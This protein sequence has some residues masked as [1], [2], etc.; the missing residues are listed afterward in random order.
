MS[1]ACT[2]CLVVKHDHLPEEAHRIRRAK[3]QEGVAHC[4]GR[5]AP[6]DLGG[7]Q[8]RG[9]LLPDEA[10]RL[11]DIDLRPA[12]PQFRLINP[13][14]STQKFRPEVMCT[15]WL[16]FLSTKLLDILSGHLCDAYIV[17]P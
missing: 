11:L 1:V 16:R 12:P 3:K 10:Q 5:H 8:V 13:S 9:E 6:V 4:S 7:V 15:F 2:V 17:N 14:N